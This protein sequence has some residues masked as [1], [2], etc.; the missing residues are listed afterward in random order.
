M[1]PTLGFAQPRNPDWTQGLQLQCQQDQRKLYHCIHGRLEG[2]TNSTLHFRYLFGAVSGVALAIWQ[3][4]P[5]ALQPGNLVRLATKLDSTPMFC[6]HPRCRLVK[7]AVLYLKKSCHAPN[8]LWCQINI[9]TP[10][11]PGTGNELNLD[12]G[13]A[14]SILPQHIVINKCWTTAP[15]Y[16]LASDLHK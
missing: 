5:N 2:N 9:N 8:S 14:Q 16:S 12:L 15:N 3:F 4:F 10:A 6:A 7:L 13:S 1:L 11:S